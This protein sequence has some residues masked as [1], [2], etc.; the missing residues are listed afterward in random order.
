MPVCP[1]CGST[2]S[3]I[4]HEGLNDPTGSAEG[5]WDLRTCAACGSAFL[6][7]QPDADTLRAAYA[8]P[9]Y[10]HA[11]VTFEEPPRGGWAFRRRAVRNGYLNRRYG[12][13]L[14]P[15]SALGPLA[16]P[17]LA[18]R[19]AEADRM[20]RSIP[21]GSSVLDVGC[22][23]GDFVALASAFG[24][25]V[26][27]LDL[28]KSAVARGRAAGLDVRVGRLEDLA[29]GEADQYDVVT[30]SHVLEHVPD[31]IGLLR[32]ARTVLRRDGFVWIATP[33]VRAAGH[34]V[35]GRDWEGV[36][37]PR[38]LVLLSEA[39]LRRVLATAGFGDVRR[40]PNRPQSPRIAAASAV[41][42]GSR[43]AGPRWTEATAR[44]LGHALN[45]LTLVRP[46]L[47]DEL[48]MIG[49]ASAVTG[50]TLPPPSR[51][52]SRAPAR[53]S[54]RRTSGRSTDEGRTPPLRP[55]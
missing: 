2:T 34:R 3:S 27:G 26:S 42:A 5:S 45:A 24:L 6:D 9:Y 54:A 19:R 55:G 11:P 29:A 15:A 13:Q 14:Q 44:A 10:T 51:P 28:D 52:M 31:P 49:H 37:A 32:A 22:G 20:I 48:C 40:A 33:N 39:S 35:F 41:R 53:G 36:D 46:G 1:V 21:A 38:H 50:R 43:G 12:F 8:G 16:L 23:N 30:M 47:G 7:P 18:L 17:L 25:R 4:L